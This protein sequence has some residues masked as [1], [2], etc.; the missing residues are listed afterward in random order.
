MNGIKR[1]NGTILDSFD[2]TNLYKNILN[3][4]FDTLEKK[5]KLFENKK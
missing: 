2:I 1:N 3:E 4:T 5:I